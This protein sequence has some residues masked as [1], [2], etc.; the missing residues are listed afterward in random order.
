MLDGRSHPLGQVSPW[1]WDYLLAVLTIREPRL[2]S[3]SR[4]TD[5]DSTRDS[6]PHLGNAVTP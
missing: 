2:A 3:Y 1:M 5:N 6:I 4:S